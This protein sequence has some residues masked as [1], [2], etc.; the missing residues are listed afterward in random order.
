MFKDVGFKLE[1]ETNS[2]VIDVSNATYY[3]NNNNSYKPSTK[4]NNPL[5]SI[6]KQQ[7][8]LATSNFL[9]IVLDYHD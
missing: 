5:L 6:C 4:S 2:K 3:L 8:T 9:E 7:L 1:I